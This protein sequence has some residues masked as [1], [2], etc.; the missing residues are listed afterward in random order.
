MNDQGKAIALILATS[1]VCV[2]LYWAAKRLARWYR[3][4]KRRR[5]GVYLVR[6]LRHGSPWRRETGYVGETVSFH[7]RK[8]DHLGRGRNG[9]DAQPWSDLDPKWY[10]PLG[11]WPWWLC[12][13]WLLRP[14]ETLVI[15]C[16]WP[17]YNGSKNYWN[18]RQIPKRAAQIQR[19]QRDGQR[20]RAAGFR[21]LIR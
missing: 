13:K 2:L 3:K 21:K 1:L 9:Q 8:L 4:V 20:V 7:F 12:W 10:Y 14:A 18:P 5:G 17:R 16:T 15:L 11:V 6:T 19:A